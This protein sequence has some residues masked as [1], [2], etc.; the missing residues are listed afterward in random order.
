MAEVPEAYSLLIGQIEKI[1]N[2]IDLDEPM[3]ALSETS[4]LI[5]TIPKETFEKYPQ[6]KKLEKKINGMLLNPRTHRLLRLNSVLKKEIETYI[7]YLD[8][9]I[10]NDARLYYQEELEAELMLLMEEIRNFIS[11]IIKERLNDDITF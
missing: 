2:A 11:I 4:L 7:E 8:E 10:G 6:I 5:K 1:M 9:D 3:T